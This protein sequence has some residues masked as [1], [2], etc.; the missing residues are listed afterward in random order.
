MSP[1]RS[2]ASPKRSNA[3]YGDVPPSSPSIGHA[4]SEHRMG[5]NFLKGSHGDTANAVLAAAGYN[6]RRL[7]AWLAIL[8]RVFILAMLDPASLVP[9]T[10]QQHLTLKPPARTRNAGYFTVDFLGLFSLEM[11]RSQG[12]SKLRPRTPLG[13][14]AEASCRRLQIA[15][16]SLRA[17]LLDQA[18]LCLTIMNV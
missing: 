11:D 1:A 7:L 12:D 9:S 8:W 2:A 3:T 13:G 16:N 17:R 15:N 18:G 5:R 6:F 4:K 14:Q 10:A